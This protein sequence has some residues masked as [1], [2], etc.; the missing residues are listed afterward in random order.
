MYINTAI[1]E[2]NRD[3]GLSFSLHTLHIPK[4][5]AV[6]YKWLAARSRRRVKTPTLFTLPDLLSLLFCKTDGESCN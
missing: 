2:C 4:R 1:V 6:G 3:K 5:N